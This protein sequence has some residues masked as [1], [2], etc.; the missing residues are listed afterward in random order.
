MKK[1]IPI[2]IISAVFLLGNLKIYAQSNPVISTV[3]GTL[4][5][6]TPKLADLDKFPT[7]LSLSPQRDE[8]GLIGMGDDDNVIIRPNHYGADQYGPDKALQQ[9]TVNTVTTASATIGTNIIGLPYT[10]VNPSDPNCAVG[11][12]HI[13]QTINNSTSSLF[14]IWDK[15]GNQVQAQTIIS[16]LTGVQGSGDPV[17]LYDQLANRWVLTEFGKTPSSQTFI[18]TLIVAVS[19]SDD[20]TGSWYIYSFVDNTFF[21]DYPK[22]SVWHNAYYATSNDFNTAATSYLGSSI[23]AFDRIK[24]LAGNVTA[25]A[26]RTRL[27]DV[28]NRYFSMA[29]VCLEGTT[30]STQSGLFAFFQDNQFTASPT[31]VDSIFI[32]EFTP[33]F[34]TPASSTISAFTKLVPT[35]FDSQVCGATRGQCISQ[36]G[37]AVAVED[38]TGR[39]MH[40]IIYRNYG[41][42]EAM[43]ANITVD[44]SG[45]SKAGIRWW[46]L[47]RPG[48]NWSIFQEG[49]WSP[50]ANHRWLGGISM[51]AIGNIGLM[52]N[53]SGAT[54]FP[55]IRFTGRNPCDALGTM[56]L[57]EQVII[58]GTVANA[59][60]RYG[61][62]NTLTTDPSTGRD[63]WLTA[64][65]NAAT[66][67][68]TRVA[69]FRL[70]NCN[71]VPVIRFDNAAL[72]L[73]EADA[74]V[75]SGCV[76]YK[77]YTV[78][79]V[80]D[81]APSANATV[82]F[83]TSGTA[84]NG[85]DYTITP[86]SVV[87]S[88]VNLSQTVTIR[89]FD[90]ASLEGNES[91]TI[92]YSINNGGGNAV[93]D[94]YNQACLVNIVDNDA[95]PILPFALTKP[96][97]ALTF[98]L[99]QTGNDPLLNSKLQSKR[100]QVLY[101][102][103]ELTAA[104]LVAGTITGMSFYLIQK[105]STRAFNNL[106]IKMGG[107]LTANLVN[108]GYTVIPVT[109]VK[110][111]FTYSTVAAFN[112]FTFDVPFV[113][114]GT[115]NIA[116]EL[117]YDNGTTAPAQT[118]DQ[119]GGYSDGSGAAIGNMFWQDA[120]N[121]SG[122][123]T[124]VTNFGSG[125]KP[126]IKLAETVPGTQISTAISS[127]KTANLGPNDD[128]YFYDA[129]G[130]II[131][132]IKNLTAFDY[133]CTQ[134]II[135]RAG[136]SSTQF[137]NN[138][139]ANYLLSK[140]CK[141][142]PTNNTASGSYQIT[143][144]YTAAEVAGW[145]AATGRTW[146]GSTMQVVKVSNGFFVPDVTPAAS[147]IA[148]VL[149]VT[150]T[151]GTFGSNFTIQGDFSSTGFSGFGVGVP[152]NALL[153]ADFQTKATGSFT[154]G[155]IWQYNNEGA[156]FIDA[157]QAPSASNNVNIQAAHTVA[158]DAG[159]A[160]N[161]GKTLTLN[162][163]LNCGTNTI[164][165]AGSFVTAA[166]STL[167]I[168]STAGIT[169]SGAIGNIQTTAR[170]FSATGNYA[171]N[172]AANQAAGNGLPVS[173]NNLLIANTGA[174]LN[175]IVSM[176]AALT[177]NGSSA[178]TSGIL[179]IGSNT[180]TLNGTL[181]GGG[182]L[183]GTASGGVSTSSLIIGG[184][185]LNQTLNFT[186]TSAATRSL[187]NLTLNSGSSATL[188][189]A[190]D[191]YGTIAL[192]TAT[193]NLNAQNLT[194][195]SNTSNTARIANLTGSTLT[196]A[197]NITMER[198]IK[199]RAGAIGRAYRLLT[200]T[201]NTI[202]SMRLN[203]MENGLNTA[204]GT[205]DDPK[206]LFGTQI[207]GAGANASGFDKT[208][209]NAASI[210][211]TTNAATPTYTAIPNTGGTMNART[212]YFLYVRGDRSMDMTLNLDPLT[213]PTSSTTLRATGT[214]L[215]GTQTSFTNALLPGAGVKNL[216]TNP[217]PSAINWASV[218]GASTDIS[219]SYTFW[220]P[221][222]G[223]RGGFVTVNTAGTA[224]SG[225]G[226]QFIQSG[227][228]FFVQS[229]NGTTPT[230]SIQESH[231]VANNNNNVFLVQ[232]P[233][234][235]SFRTELYYTQPDGFRRIVDGAI[236]VY[237]N[238]YSTA[239]DAK[240]ASEINNWDENIA[241]NREGK[242]LAIESRPVIKLRDT[243][244]LFMN[245]MKQRGYE[246]EFVPASFSNTG[247]KAVLIDNFLGTRTLLS[248]VD[249][250]VVPFAI[251]SDIASSAPNR[252]MIIFGPKLPIAIDVLAINAQVK[253]GAVQVNWTARTEQDMDRYELE[254]SADRINF[255]LI[256]TT[257]AVGSS[258]VEVNYNWLD[259][260][261][262]P[263]KGFYRV[264]AIDKSGQV[265]YTDIVKV[266]VDYEYSDIT[267]FPNPVSSNSIG[268]Q[269]TDMEKG[270]YHVTIVN[271]PGQK[272]YQTDVQHAGGS[273]I[274]TVT[275][276]NNLP[277]GIY[278]IVIT[279]AGFTINKSFVKN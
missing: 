267:I 143:L 234:P 56:S 57:P 173:I 35:D 221:N 112:D 150:G 19:V 125:V 272:I 44:A 202:G 121:C 279:K 270:S 237:N 214:I 116:V 230:V 20:P 245:N 82:T 209:T 247:L 71:P 153:T 29:P 192:T 158:L 182:T 77:D 107:T 81:A 124:T 235:E 108:G 212:G 128:V 85:V 15:A 238:S 190:L 133:G 264:K 118:S 250:V 253:N 87:L 149:L 233:P 232:P 103:T 205:N 194:L 88:N 229:L 54:A 206:L 177:V 275:P 23:Y 25:T 10:G 113:W 155:S 226:T 79:V 21:V 254:R 220:D 32:F 18:N 208:Q 102:A 185:A 134:I 145:E 137:W 152:G 211:S 156:T 195:K 37:S 166:A 248:V 196:G 62:Y 50:D 65:Y 72:A 14:K 260:N 80:I 165:G 244:P 101:K 78:N 100:L 74:N 249:T 69:T 136:S 123:F 160:I 3:T 4:I 40:K 189:N 109:T 224:S 34:I 218:Y 178:L 204:I 114:N 5:R 268:L 8:D 83:N 52:Y 200:P 12:N 45:A 122:T 105:N 276:A 91:F 162:G 199:L 129:S 104:G 22:F 132:R 17:V 225:A 191:V 174:A 89:V 70:N 157:L 106:T 222:F 28:G 84:T 49:T 126:I 53:T 98:N 96:V 242:H 271:K 138:A 193:L 117:C 127:T 27:T 236:A 95:A 175:N 148:D 135:D 240:D 59:S 9:S 76:K 86:A 243:I 210:Y 30:P 239:V 213:N 278:E 110:N 217:Y 228:A 241:I 167:G 274:I 262:L 67:W 161:T 263:A 180:L 63:F 252:F 93:A 64:Q 198:W 99:V 13:I 2:F 259:A 171:Y 215:Q 257:A 186:Q 1:L 266:N 256:N 131:A 46:E 144:Y 188:G 97:G 16:S 55:S 201:V 26:I 39:I 92:S 43:V 7:G 151:K 207:T 277:K 68:S 227:Q 255:N 146:T 139:T 48:G 184:T 176:S 168:G 42:Y 75:V 154:D 181:S 115:D 147:H 216:I 219:D 120:I 33:D 111:P 265:K 258:P 141:V 90:D 36:Q 6:V 47:R 246:F 31:D 58:A 163:T 187:N 179:S 140:T 11:P 170:T 61:D 60:T 183:T 24:M 261:P 159:F 38:L 169:A 231:K 197:T 119:S 269:F 73:R 164:S 94:I 251:S 223:N 203:W 172:G 142:I 66:T 273:A 51:D 130:N 41:S